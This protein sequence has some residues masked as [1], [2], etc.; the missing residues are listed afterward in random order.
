MTD[1]YKAGPGEEQRA[2][3][4]Q[5]VQEIVD[6]YYVFGPT[7][8]RDA[9][10]TL[11]AQRLADAERR[12]REEGRAEAERLREM[13]RRARDDADS[14]ADAVVALRQIGDIIG[15]EHTDG[16]DDR[17]RLVRCVRDAFRRLKSD[18]EV[19]TDMLAGR[20]ISS[21]LP[22]LFATA[23][24]VSKLHDDNADLRAEL[25]SLAAS[26]DALA[27]Q[28]RA[29]AGE[30]DAWSDEA[31]T[32]LGERN[33]VIGLLVRQRNTEHWWPIVGITGTDSP[34]EAV[35]IAAGLPRSGQA[36]P[37]AAPE[38][39]CCE[40]CRRP[41]GGPDWIDVTV[42]NDQWAMLAGRSDGGGL[43]CGA[44]MVRR[45]AKLPG[46]VAVRMQIAFPPQA[47]PVAGEEVRP[48]PCQRCKGTGLECPKRQLYEFMAYLSQDRHFAGWLIGLEY[49]LWAEVVGDGPKPEDT[50]WH[51]YSAE[52]TLELKRLAALAGGWWA[53]PLNSSGRID[54]NKDTAFVPM[55]EWLKQYDAY[56]AAR[57]A[58]QATPGAAEGGR[59]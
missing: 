6:G 42:S 54:I 5:V 32:M 1:A 26:R 50:P 28:L 59:S 40:D 35:R 34:A 24:V 7:F 52:D 14:T 3:A 53:D 16:P 57:A 41:Y 22:A 20:E 12:G 38:A 49:T 43:L 55:A 17:A 18:L 56:R 48:V 47:A 39:A 33:A 45:A 29:A 19:A 13:A 51:I 10:T 58:A 11:V 37:Q 46:A 15:C 44:C 8:C 31:A 36:P 21:A 4:E 25:A 27:E 23:N 9:V 30:R 2:E